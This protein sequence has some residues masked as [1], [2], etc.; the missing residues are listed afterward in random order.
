MFDSV[1][2][3]LDSN[4][5]LVEALIVAITKQTLASHHLLSSFLSSFM[6]YTA[7]K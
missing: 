1:I 3:Y 4:T 2:M 5:G 7:H 6:S